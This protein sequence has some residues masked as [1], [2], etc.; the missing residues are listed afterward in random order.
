MNIEVFCYFE[1]W[2]YLHCFLTYSKC[3]T[4]SSL[5][6]MLLLWKF[7]QFQ[8]WIYIPLFLSLSSST[9]NKRT[10]KTRVCFHLEEVTSWLHQELYSQ[11]SFNHQSKTSRLLIRRFDIKH[12]FYEYMLRYHHRFAIMKMLILNKYSSY[13]KIVMTLNYVKYYIEITHSWRQN[14]QKVYDLCIV[15]FITSW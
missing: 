7:Y 9:G 11:C 15:I 6:F 3:N 1:S 13:L 2:T 8:T 12:T 14:Y 10:Y 4:L 5:S